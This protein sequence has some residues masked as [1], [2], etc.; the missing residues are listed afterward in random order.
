MNSLIRV[1]F[2]IDYDSR[3]LTLRP[4]DSLPASSLIEVQ[5]GLPVITVR[6]EGEPVRLLVDTGAEQLIVFGERQQSARKQRCTVGDQGGPA[7]RPGQ[8]EVTCCAW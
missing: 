3:M 1:S 7:R 5:A 8:S 2:R 4:P 6:L